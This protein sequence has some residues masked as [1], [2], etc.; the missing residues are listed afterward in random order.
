MPFSV[1]VLVYTIDKSLALIST[2]S[3]CASVKFIFVFH[4]HTSLSKSGYISKRLGANQVIL[5]RKLKL[6]FEFNR[7]WFCQT[8]KATF[9]K[10]PWN[11][12]SFDKWTS[13]A[14][15]LFRSYIYLYD[16]SILWISFP[17]NI[18]PSFISQFM[19]NWHNHDLGPLNDVDIW[20][21]P[22]QLSCGDICQ[23]LKWYL[24]DEGSFHHYENFFETITS[25]GNLVKAIPPHPGAVQCTPITQWRA[26]KQSQWAV[27][28]K[29][30]VKTD[31]DTL[32]LSCN[33]IQKLIIPEKNRTRLKHIS[34]GRPVPLISYWRELIVICIV[35]KK[36]ARNLQ[37]FRLTRR[38]VSWYKT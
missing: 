18:R 25:D 36:N 29:L 35:F 22:P 28:D 34:P 31:W 10:I 26:R 12:V 21:M 17:L 9:I 13:I 11:S 19:W 14:W 38:K 37:T 5:E 15:S 24:R 2:V 6:H 30:A 27:T 32:P 23:I 33:T 20:Q 8:I 3:K 16:C 1:W 7:R 4:D